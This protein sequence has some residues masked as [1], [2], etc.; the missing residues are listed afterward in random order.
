MPQSPEL[1][2]A[3]HFIDPDRVRE[4]PTSVDFSRIHKLLEAIYRRC[5][6]KDEMNFVPPERV[7]ARDDLKTEKKWDTYYEWVKNY[8]N[9]S[10]DKIRGIAEKRGF[11]PE[12]IFLHGVIHEEIHATATPKSQGSDVLRSG[13]YH[14]YPKGKGDGLSPGYTLYSAWNEGVTEKLARE[15]TRKYLEEVRGTDAGAVQDFDRCISEEGEVLSKVEDWRSEQKAILPYG[16]EVMLVDYL[17]DVVSQDVGV[18]RETVWQAFVRGMYDEDVLDVMKDFQKE[19]VPP[20]FGGSRREPTQLSSLDQQGD[21]KHRTAIDALRAVRDRKPD[22]WK[23]FIDRLG[24]ASN[25]DDESA[26]EEI[27]A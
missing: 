5:G 13:Y 1:E 27:A 11:T 14:Y 25:H 3:Q 8:I 20:Q 26:E 12:T 4:A 10:L 19:L 7:Y 16:S 23:K 22:A 24:I 21:P 17:I 6:R 18:S 2:I 9:I 15:V